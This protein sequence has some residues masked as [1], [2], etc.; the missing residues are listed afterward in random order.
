MSYEMTPLDQGRLYR[1]NRAAN[2]EQKMAGKRRKT[3]SN[4]YIPPAELKLAM[5]NHKP[6]C[7]LCTRIV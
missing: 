2:M 4:I 7:H 3:S 5:A 1:L 6:H